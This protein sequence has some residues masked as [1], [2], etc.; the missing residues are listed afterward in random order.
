M[1]STTKSLL[2]LT[3]AAAIAAPARATA[4][5]FD[6]RGYDPG[7]NVISDAY[8]KQQVSKAVRALTGW[9]RVQIKLYSRITMHDRPSAGSWAKHSAGYIAEPLDRGKTTA[10]ASMFIGRVDLTKKGPRRGV[11]RLY[12]FTYPTYPN[13]HSY[14]PLSQVV[15]RIEAMK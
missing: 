4:A 3:L 1:S 2:L 7:K 11:D 14:H 13:G 15:R 8:A 5:P 12:Q 6:L 9:K 10:T